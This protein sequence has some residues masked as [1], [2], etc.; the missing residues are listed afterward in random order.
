MKLQILGTGCPKCKALFQAAEQAN[1][2][3]GW[4]AEL[5]K[6]ED[7]R[8]IIQF[9]VMQT[10]ALALDGRVLV[11]GRVPSAKEIAELVARAR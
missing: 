9:G 11:T 2:A 5:E 4:N 1:Q 6:I 8:K 7:I 3:E 10:P